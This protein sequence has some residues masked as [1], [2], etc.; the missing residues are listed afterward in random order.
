MK[1]SQ[2]QKT[3]K[4]KPNYFRLFFLV[5]V[6]GFLIGAS[7][8]NYLML[9][10]SLGLRLNPE[11]LSFSVEPYPQLNNVQGSDIS[12]EGFAVIDSDSHIIFYSKNSTRFFSP[13]STT[14]ILTAL[15]G[16]QKFSLNDVLTVHSEGIEG[17]IIGLKKGDKLTFESL[18]YAMMLPSSNDAAVAVAENNPL[19]KEEFIQEM[20]NKAK[21]L[22]LFS[23]H[24]IDP[25][26]IEDETN[27]TTPA[28]LAV[29]GDLAMRDPILSEVVKTKV[30]TIKTLDG[31]EFNL[32]NLNILLGKDG[33]DGIKTGFTQ[34]SGQVL[35]STR[36]EDNKR[37]VISVMQSQDRFGDTQK[38]LNLLD[39]GLTYLTIHP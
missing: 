11:P 9:N 30:K 28:D 16:L 17:S 25:V 39:S 26:G 37:V 20:N 34:T 22:G 6:L 31:K 19:G 24:L 33:I 32:T 10:A 18:L 38:I 36:K 7:V 13:A 8:A 27:F 15:V 14:K 1:D 29:L 12:A 4:E 2:K 23:T 35:V 5:V 21:E 3:K